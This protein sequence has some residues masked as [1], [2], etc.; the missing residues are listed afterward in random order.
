[1]GSRFTPEHLLGGT[2][3][4]QEREGT[5]S[6]EGLR[7][8]TKVSLRPTKLD[9]TKLN[10]QLS[11]T[12]SVKLDVG[13]NHSKRQKSLPEPQ[14]L[15]SEPILCPRAGRENFGPEAEINTQT[16][17][18][19]YVCCIQSGIQHV[20]VV[21]NGDATKQS[22][23]LPLQVFAFNR[24]YTRPMGVMQIGVARTSNE[25][26]RAKLNE[27]LLS[28]LYPFYIYFYVYMCLCIFSRLCL[29][30]YIYTCN[31][32]SSKSYLYLCLE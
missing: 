6:S 31:E 5:S 18:L 32:I 28:D 20:R 22:R 12:R 26:V 15:L 23:C 7:L 16:T 4:V 1:M 3:Q 8:E 13:T 19:L 17:V 21:A 14:G 10:F 9:P 29:C 30:T 11:D 25:A 2:S 27:T 24:Q